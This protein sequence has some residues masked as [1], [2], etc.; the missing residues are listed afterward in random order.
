MNI[1][2]ICDIMASLSLKADQRVLRH[3]ISSYLPEVDAALKQHDIG[4]F[5]FNTVLLFLSIFE[6]AD[7]DG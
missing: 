2:K 5:G 7:V 3:L 6:D 4:L 1:W